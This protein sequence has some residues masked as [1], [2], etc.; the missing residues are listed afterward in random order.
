[1][2][3]N[4]PNLP[5]NQ[6]AYF[7]VSAKLIQGVFRRIL[8]FIVFYLCTITNVSAQCN[9]ETPLPFINGSSFNS[10]TATGNI[11]GGCTFLT[12]SA[13][14]ES[15]LIDSDLN[16]F[17]T[18]TVALGVGGFANYRVT[19]PNIDYPAGTYAGYRI[20]SGG[21]L[22]VNLLGGITIKTYLNGTFR[23]SVTAASLLSLGLLKFTGSDYVVGFNTKMGFDAIEISVGGLVGLLT[24]VNVYYPVIR[25]YCQGPALTCN[26]ATA[27]N[28]PTYPVYIN[29]DHTGISAVACVNCSVDNA[30]NAISS[31]ANDFAQINLTAG[32]A[33]LGRLSVKD[34]FTDYPAGTYAGFEIENTNLL[35]VSAL[36]NVTVT[37][38]LNGVLKE[39]ISGNNLVAG[40]NLL[41]TSG[42]N[43]IGFV[44]TTDFD[45]V[46]I[47]L[48]QILGVTLGTTKV[49]NAVFEKFC[50]GP[51]LACNT[52]TEMVAPT[53]PVYING[54]NTGIGGAV[55][56]L[57]SVKNTEKLIDNDASTYAEIDLTTGVLA[58]GS[59]SVKDQITDYPSG[60]FV[61]FT[62]E[63]PSLLNVNA[64]DA[65]AITTYLNGVLQESKSGNTALAIVGTNLLLGS[66]KQTIGF[67]TSQPFDE[68]RITVQNTA[69]V[70]LGLV[71][72]YNAVF[73][74][75]CPVTLLC[76]TTYSWTNPTF[77]VVVDNSKTGVDGVACVSCAV[78]DTNNVLTA[79]TTD[80]AR[81]RVAA[82]VIAP[83]S[84]AVLDQL[85]TYPKGTFAGFTIRDRNSLV[86]LDLFSALTVSTYLDGVFQ[87]SRNAGNLLNL[88]LLT[89][90]GSG[91]G[92]YNVGFRATKSFDEIRITVGSLASVINDIDVFGAFVNTSGTSGGTLFCAVID[93]VNDNFPQISG[94]TGNSN[95]ANVLTNDTLSGNP[96]AISDVDLTVTSP[97]TPKSSGAPV[98]SIDS[99][100]G[101]VSVP[102]NTPAG[103]YSITYQIC[104]K[105]NALTCDSATVT[106][107]VTA[108]AIDA[109]ADN[110][111]IKGLTG[112]DAGINVFGNDKLNG[113]AVNPSDVNFSSTPSGP[114]TVNAD[115]TVTVSPNTPAGIYTVDYTICEKLNPTNCDTATV[116]ITV[117]SA[118]I[119]AVDDNGTINGVIGG[120]IGINVFGNDKLNGV[121]VNPSAI[122]FSSTPNGPLTVNADGT[123]TVLPTTPAG[124]YTVDYTICE[125]LNPGNC[126]TATVTVAVTAPVILANDDTATINGYTGGVPPVNVL[127]NDTLNGTPVTPSEITLTSTPNGPLTVNTDGSITVAPNTPAGTYTVTYQ[128]CE[129]LNQGNCDTAT[130]TVTVTAAV[131]LANDDVGDTVGTVAGGT[132]LQNVLGNDTLNGFLVNSSQVNITFVSST[133]PGIS[134]SGTDVVVAAGTPVGNYTLTYQICEKLNPANCDLAVVNVVV[135]STAPTILA[136]N[137][138]GTPVN[139]Y[140]GGTAF[141]NVLVNDTLNGAPATTSNVDISFVGSTDP[142]IT[143]SGTD[144][145]VAAGTPAGAY[146]LDYKICDKSDSTNCDGARVTITV[147]PAVILANDD[148]GTNIEGHLGGTAFSNILTNDT[149]NGAAVA[150]SQVNTTFVSSTNPGITLSGTDVIVLAGTQ[151]GSYSLTY[152]ICEKLNPSNCDTATVTVTVTA[153]VILANNDATSIN[154]YTGGIAPV[155][156]LTN[157]TLN[158]NPVNP[159]EVTLIS[160][161]NGPLT[162]NTGGTITV[163][164]NTAA[165]DYTVNYQ[166]CEKLNPSNCSTATVTVTVTAAI[167]LAND[168]TTSINGYTGGTPS[169]NVLTN[170]TLNGTQVIPSEVTLTSTPNGPLTVNADGSITVAPNTAAG[171]H[172]VTYQICEKLNPTNCDTATVSVTVTAAAIDAVDDSLPST[173]GLVGNSNIGNVL[174][175]DTLNGSPVVIGDVNL[176]VSTPATP[177]FVGAPVPSVDLATGVVGVPSGTPAGNYTITY[178][179]CEKLNPTNCD[180]ATVTI[181]VS[182][183]V[184]DAVADANTAPVYGNTGGN[185]GIN[186]FAND[187]LG[188]N[189]VNPA[190]VNFSST[191]NGP[192]TINTDGSVVVAPNTPAGTY[193]VAYTIC[194]KLNP[195]NCDSATVTITVSAAV[196]DAV[197]DA[198]IVP[199]YG[200]TGGNTGINVFANDTLGGNPVN[201]ADVNFSSTPNGPLTVNTDG[202]VTV[203]PNTPAGTY[204]VAYTICEKLNPTNCDTATVTVVVSFS[205][206]AVVKTGVVGGIGKVGDLIT[207]TFTV[208]NTGNTT[209]NNVVINDVLTN[210][211]N[212]AV[213]PNVLAPNAIGTATVTYTI[214]QSDIDAGKVTNS[215]TVTGTTPTGGTVTDT[216]GTT[217]TNDTPTVTTLSSSSGIAVVKT[218]VVGGTIK[219]GD[220]ITYTFTVTNTG[221][222]TLNNIVI[223]DALTNSVNL[224]VSP[225]TLTPNAIGT[226]TVTYAIKQFDIDAGKVT[227]SATVTGTT[228]TGSTVT[229]TSGTTIAN[230]TPTVT[231]LN[232]NPGIAV[233]KTGV[234]GGTVKVGDLITYTFT[235][236]NT[237]NI[238]L[239]NIVINDALTNSVNLT[240]SPS[241]LAPNAIGA[242]TVTYAIKQSDIDAGK[243]TNSATVTGTIPTGGTVTDTSGTAINNDNPTVTT[244]NST[245]GISIMKEGTY[246]DKNKDGIANVGDVINYSFTVTNT[247]NVSL[248]NIAIQDNN[249]PAI[250][251]TLN[252]LAGGASDSVTFTAVYPITNADIALGYAYNSALISAITSTNNSVTAVSVD[253]TPCTQCPIL[254][255]CLTCTITAIPQ[256]P[257]IAIVKKGIFK[258]ENGDGYAEIGETIDYSFTVMNTGNL[259]LTNVTLTD[260]LLGIVIS[261]GPINL[262]VGATD[263]TSFKGTYHIT[264]QDIVKGSVTN[265]AKIKGITPTGAEV[266][267]MSDDDSPLQDDPTVLG[268][269]G[270]SLEVFNA[271][272]PDGDGL[273]DI[274]RIR[275]I[276]CYPKNTVQVFNRWGVKVYE[277]DGYNNDTVAFKGVSEG[278]VTVNKS[279]GL[280]SG[281]YFYVI[282]YEDFSGTGIDKS[283]YLNISRD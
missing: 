236:T 263:G 187:T 268:I 136:N 175:N 72:V 199:V 204:T 70:N 212:L 153:P 41:N 80:Y 57:C 11:T 189:P 180:S 255:S 157:D 271:V 85:S 36:A 210:S 142:R 245:S 91:S 27:M 241:A 217:I 223:N 82:G 168:D 63:N 177:A 171:N 265:Q 117:T 34:Q 250:K 25:S 65:I 190:D 281:T 242:A 249:V 262:A 88:S 230:N 276:E 178:Q 79:S 283:G 4:Y 158:G 197:A 111:T 239:S 233:V 121:A 246:E 274:F 219:M 43:K 60:S 161:P 33:A 165:G 66:S 56:A 213:N 220:L 61:G 258:D 5:F 24:S 195:T 64:L 235:V 7:I 73:E 280:P 240:V 174:T 115:G 100:T 256:S 279:E 37:T 251:G 202:S 29:G 74:N 215:A 54:E 143:L 160:T 26:T 198:N 164:P 14:N 222:T 58:S 19:D 162:V 15:R 108:A 8:L 149:L 188:G 209:L 267:D 191:P 124:T 38:Y 277:A 69:T 147:I 99:V 134:L 182:A 264:Q 32:I 137:D 140:L 221:N 113:V 132:A 128:I 145:I 166:I 234:V 3:K 282:K 110:S 248:S 224:A 139:G 138:T 18:A 10:L 237:G 185:T 186:V 151:A 211:V 146:S 169:I 259:P 273:N 122:N 114:L 77:P 87:E 231:T 270:C 227:N 30:E 40:T 170:D 257:S 21:L 39:T 49:Y 228:P 238:T 28:L 194:E 107:T 13:S 50:A 129:K 112:G 154:G 163:A 232:S 133:N 23:E 176:T 105:L 172:M 12:C 102:A 144:V 252:S 67:V 89:P 226:A 159:S 135:A 200:N 206:I 126:D 272:S 123:V 167:I 98:P 45:E 46:Q 196:I 207:Y 94:L 183:A 51:A 17:A 261:G 104:Y 103:A 127:T 225:S 173:L 118:V 119:D 20:N 9:T 181:T 109:V 81:I 76:N 152:Q 53:Y 1:M 68:A 275:G 47:S 62:V 150:S 218:G 86:Q 42:R 84:I 155:N 35:T 52:Q 78:D 16:N 141:T 125:K 179:I 260:A 59:I 97:A 131:I 93:A 96:V 83:S 192:L 55:C 2:K 254:S 22:D 214:K 216:S 44:S 116:T 75:L 247:G 156:V 203:A 269:E 278:R 92:I 71:K 6:L 101:I 148:T 244:L 90:Y 229:D 184:I 243:V 120:D 201:P 31:D 208:T 205:S 253:P 266:T 48:N 106:V 130:V 193:T 95:V